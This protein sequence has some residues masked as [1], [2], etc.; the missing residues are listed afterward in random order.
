MALEQIL[1]NNR[2][3]ASAVE[4]S[5]PGFFDELAKGQHPDYLWL[6]CSDSRV[7]TNLLTGLDVGD[8]FVHRNVANL[9]YRDDPNFLSVLQYAVEVLDVKE[10]IVCGH[11]SCGGVNAAIQGGTVGVIDSWLTKLREL[12]RRER[13]QLQGLDERDRADRLCELN[14]A[15]QVQTISETDIVKGH[16]A[17]GKPLAIHGLIYSLKDGSI[18]N[19]NLSRES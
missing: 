2:K 19:L 18:T 11:Y 4:E 7:A 12:Y 10:V 13:S 16:W 3:W 9:V 5:K 1:E 8:I 14:V 17:Q 6:G 15:D